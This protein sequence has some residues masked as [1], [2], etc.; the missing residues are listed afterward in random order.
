MTTG[1]GWP[2][3]GGQQLH[4]KLLM[5]AAFYTLRF[6]SDSVRENIRGQLVFTGWQTEPADLYAGQIEAEAAAW[7]KEQLADAY[8]A[9]MADGTGRAR[10]TAVEQQ[11]R[12]IRARR[13]AERREDAREEQEAA[14]AEGPV[15][16]R[17]G[18][19]LT[20]QRF[21]PVE[22]AVPG[23]I[24][25]GVAIFGGPPKGGKSWLALSV[26]LSLASGGQILGA[27]HNGPPRPVLYFALEDSDRRMKRRCAELGYH[28]IPPLFEYV[29][30]CRPGR[31]IAEIAAWLAEHKGERPLV[32]IDTW[33]KIM[34]PAARGET[35]YERD[36]RLGGEVAALAARSPGATV[37]VNHHVRKERATDWIELI[38]GTNAVTGF[39]DTVAVLVRKRH[40]TMGRLHITGRDVEEETYQLCGFPVWA[41]EGGELSAAAVAA[42]MAAERENLG[43][44]SAQL[45]DEIGRLGHITTAEAADLLGITTDAASTYLGRLAKAGKIDKDG[46][47]SWVTAGPSR[48]SHIPP[49]GSVGSVGNM[50]E[51]QQ[52]PQNK[53]WVQG[54][55][56]E[57]DWQAM[58]EDGDP[59]AMGGGK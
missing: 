31:V 48:V 13:E 49:V 34:M 19:W 5:D 6:G 20:G 2:Q 24:P 46:R 18:A 43:E 54:M 29:T 51:S 15:V 42:R 12:S 41:M 10:E 3:G 44:R 16:I 39:A 28:Q 11:Q 45:L 36:Y 32:I 58:Y 56:P 4:R 30:Q 8:R 1:Q 14:A 26:G 37:W 53:Q 33:G 50:G 38:S 55:P 25:E 7:S 23:L 40:E 52:N 59:G 57:P 21:G 17:D 27:L 35:V 22:F 47:G 9:A